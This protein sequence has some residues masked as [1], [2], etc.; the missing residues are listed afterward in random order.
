MGQM[1]EVRH[2]ESVLWR[3]GGRQENNRRWKLPQQICVPQGFL[4]IEQFAPLA[5]LFCGALQNQ[6]ERDHGRKERSGSVFSVFSQLREAWAR[7]IRFERDWR[8]T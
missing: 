6:W 2:G 5:R 4:I 7:I 1:P 8:R 3:I